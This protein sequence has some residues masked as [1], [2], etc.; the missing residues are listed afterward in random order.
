MRP[1]NVKMDDN[2]DKQDVLAFPHE[3]DKNA[4]I[5]TEVTSD[6]TARRIQ[7][8]EVLAQP[9][10]KNST[11]P[12]SERKGIDP[13]FTEQ[14]SLKL[15]SK[16]M[17]SAKLSEDERQQNQLNALEAKINSISSTL[18]KLL[19]MLQGQTATMLPNQQIAQAAIT[20][21]P[22]KPEG[23]KEKS[24]VPHFNV[25]S[26]S[27]PVSPNMLLLSKMPL[28]EEVLLPFPACLLQALQEEAQL[29]LLVQMMVVPQQAPPNL[30]VVP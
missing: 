29:P 22:T 4:G 3:E 23:D 20:T 15:R 9:E 11:P 2:E 7:R 14:R 24:N 26:P 5:W 19:L 16:V 18:D 10:K 21:S 6:K 1:E 30:K 12:N 27:S 8:Q 13:S 28:V 17:A 25:N